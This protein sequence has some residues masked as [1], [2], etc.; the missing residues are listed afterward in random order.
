MRA[1]RL[2][3]LECDEFKK[4]LMS[5]DLGTVLDNQ[6]GGGAWRGVDGWMGVDGGNAGAVA[7]GGG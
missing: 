3:S 6:V 5:L 1:R 4:V 2:G 7:A